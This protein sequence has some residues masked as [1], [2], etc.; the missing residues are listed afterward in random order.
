MNAN[1]FPVI[2]LA[3]AFAVSACR[4][5]ASP[6]VVSVEVTRVVAVATTP[7]RPLA[8]PTA[9]AGGAASLE[10]IASS[11]TVFA[12]GP[13]QWLDFRVQFNRPPFDAETHRL[14]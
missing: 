13:V 3:L 6:P 9:V 5:F 14:A 10:I 11:T 12:A 7:F 8:T 1:R 4:P 2:L